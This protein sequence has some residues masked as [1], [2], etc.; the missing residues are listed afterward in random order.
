MACSSDLEVRIHQC[1]S[2]PDPILRRSSRSLLNN[3]KHAQHEQ[4]PGVAACRGGPILREFKTVNG[5]ACRCCP[6]CPGLASPEL[7]AD[8]YTWHQSSAVYWPR[9]AGIELLLMA[10]ASKLALVVL[11]ACAGSPLQYRQIARV[12]H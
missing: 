7:P 1:L 2:H 6:A 10:L 5:P 12:G 4:T 3:R 8:P 11:L 9:P